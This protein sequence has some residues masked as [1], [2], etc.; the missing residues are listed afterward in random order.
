MNLRVLSTQI[1]CRVLKEGQSLTAALDS[2]LESLDDPKERA[3]VQALCYGVLR[4]Y[5][6]LDFLLSL[7]MKKPL[8]NK[9]TDIKVLML[10]GL[11]QLRTM[12]IKTHAA[13]SETVAAIG[14]KSWAKGVINGV[15][16]EYLREQEGLEAKA[17]ADVIA[18]SSH[19]EWLVKK[20]N[21]DWGEQ[22]ANL[23]Q[24]NNQQPPMVLRVNLAQT[25]QADYFK[26]LAENNIEAEI[27]EFSQ[28]AIKLT[29]AVPV[30]LL[31]RFD[32]GFVSVQDTAAQ[33]AAPLLQ[34]EQ[35][36]R[37]LDMC[38][39]PGGKTA[40]MLESCSSLEMTAMDIEATR[41]QRVTDNLQRLKLKAT[42][43]EGDAA[44]PD[45]WWDGQLFERIL[46]D[47]PC[48]ALG[49]IRRHPDIKVLR[50]DSDIDELAKLQAEILEAA[51]NLLTSG[52]ILLY[53]TCSVLKQENELQIEKFLVNH[54][55]SFEMPIEADWG[56]QRAVG[57]QILTGDKA[58]DG[59]YYARLGKR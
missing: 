17:D 10:M 12:R 23:L 11:Y 59:F 55:D 15:L 19:P 9:D 14:K 56:Q 5:H 30:E 8:R 33:F 36:Q 48:S 40:A 54:T 28:T 31:P 32:D 37:V 35:G 52:G 21:K 18:S 57:R 3:F 13:V 20:I 16:R 43:V 58:M 42:V 25:N 26:L 41:L 34:L 1:L 7:L 50:R 22:A 49:V 51:W 27:V 53:A 24:Q 45:E 47:A 2:K 4:D 29:Q 44:K 6:R 39:A 38:A 46:L